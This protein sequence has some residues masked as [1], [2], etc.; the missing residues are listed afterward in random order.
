MGVHVSEKSSAGVE[1]L[2]DP[3][4]ASESGSLRNG[5][6]W[7][8][9]VR[10]RL[11]QVVLEP[12]VPR[13]SRIL[14]I[15]SA[16]GPSVGWMAALGDRIATDLDPRGLAPGGVCASATQL[17]FADGSMDVVA[18]FDVIEHIADE[19]AVL[20]EVHRVLSPKGVLLVSVP[21]YQWAWSGADV[22]AGHHRRYTR[23]RLRQALVENGFEVSRMTHVFAGTFPAFAVDRLQARVRGRD[24]ERVVDSSMPVW[25]ERLLMRLSRF[26]ERL[27]RRFDLPFGSSVVAVAHR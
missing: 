23:D 2:F 12:A 1:A 11:L 18:A 14:E 22:A 15:G 10:Q 17:P 8:Y 26:D 9:R 21:A 13:G 4:R 27:L 25:Q 19:R 7:W 3:D 5:E 20:G 16:D 24:P 6:Y